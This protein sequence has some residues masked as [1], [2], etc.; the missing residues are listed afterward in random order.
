MRYQTNYETRAQVDWN[1]P[2]HTQITAPFDIDG[3]CIV[4]YNATYNG[5][6]R[7]TTV[8]AQLG[9]DRCMYCDDAT[10]GEDARTGSHCHVG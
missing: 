10:E 7:I 4:S 9:H 8:A 2:L 6:T 1:G 3:D 5:T